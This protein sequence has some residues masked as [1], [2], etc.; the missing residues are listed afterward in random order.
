MIR[1]MAHTDRLIRAAVVAPVLVV[2]ALLTG[3]ATVV[4]AVL[5]VAAVVMLATA[6]TGFCPLYRLFGIDTRSRVR[7]H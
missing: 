3:A 6:A 5:L 2:A 4:G 7:T 1:N